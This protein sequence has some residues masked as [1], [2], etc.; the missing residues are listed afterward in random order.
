MY[1]SK[2]IKLLSF[3]ILLSFLILFYIKNNSSTQ[4]ILF[5]QNSIR[6]LLDKSKVSEIC[7]KSESNIETYF[8]KPNF[9]YPYD[10]NENKWAN[11]IIDFIRNEKTEDFIKN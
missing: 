5:N 3:T 8:Y 11:Y 4:I 9:D 1:K 7:S 10:I 6:N 2:K